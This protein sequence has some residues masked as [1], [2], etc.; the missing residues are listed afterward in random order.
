MCAV[1]LIHYPI[2]LKSDYDVIL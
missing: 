1:S 2:L